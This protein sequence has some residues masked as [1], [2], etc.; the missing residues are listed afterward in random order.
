MLMKSAILVMACATLPLLLAGCQQAKVVT[1]GSFFSDDSME[2]SLEVARRTFSV[3]E[4]FDVAIRAR[5]ISRQ[6]ITIRA[7]SGAPV[8]LHVNRFTALGEDEFKT[9]PRAATMVM[10]A[11]TIQPG[12]ERTFVLTLAVEADWPRNEPLKLIAELNGY[13]GLMPCTTIRVLPQTPP[14]SPAGK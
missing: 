11:W 1:D 8:Y 13:S 10:S 9:F 5:N 6:P 4:T 14:A 12:E 7:R 3:G 2:M